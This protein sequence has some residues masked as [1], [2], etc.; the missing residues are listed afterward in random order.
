M[1]KDIARAKP[2]SLVEKQKTK[3]RQKKNETSD[4]LVGNL[5]VSSS[6]VSKSLVKNKSFQI[7]DDEYKVIEQMAIAGWDEARI[8]SVFGLT[9]TDFIKSIGE[10]SKLSE[11]IKFGRQIT[12]GEVAESLFK[13]A[14]GYH[15]FEEHYEDKDGQMILKKKVRKHIPGDILAANTFLNNRDPQNWKM[16][17]DETPEPPKVKINVKLSGKQYI[18]LMKSNYKNIEDAVVVK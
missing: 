18:E 2:K 5:P 16:K 13:R 1:L 14:K 7:S 15:Y 12:I 10:D 6:S 8:S 17:R 11:A 3:L 4:S 9:K